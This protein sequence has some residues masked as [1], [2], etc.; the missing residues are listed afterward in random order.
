MPHYLPETPHSP[1]FFET[2]SQIAKTIFHI[3]KEENIS[4]HS[5]TLGLFGKWGSGKSL[6]IK[7]IKDIIKNEADTSIVLLE[8]DVW[9]YIDSSLYRSILFDLERQ[10]QN[11]PLAR[12]NEHFIEGYK[13]SY[14]GESLLQIL[15]YQ[16]EHTFYSNTNK[17]TK[18]VSSLISSL[19]GYCRKQK[20]LLIITIV[21][22]F[23][24]GLIYA[25]KDSIHNTLPNFIYH[26]LRILFLFV[27]C[28]GFIEFIKEFFKDFFK[29]MLPQSNIIM[30]TTAPTFAQ[31][32]FEKIFKDFIDQIRRIKSNSK[33]A[34]VFDNLDRCDSEMAL[35]TLAGL[36]TFMN[37]PYCFYLIPCDELEIKKHLKEE[38]NQTGVIDKVFQSFIRIPYITEEDKYRFIEKCIQDAEFLI[39]KSDKSK[40]VQVLTY[41]YEG[42]TPRQ[43]KRFFNDF[44]SYYKLA[45]VVDKDKKFL[46]KNIGMFTFMITLKQK[47][48]SVEQIIISSPSFFIEYFNTRSSEILGKDIGSF[49]K[50]LDTCI[51]W[52]DL[53]QDPLDFI[54]FKQIKESSLFVR[55]ALKNDYSKLDISESSI[56]EIN[57]ILTEYITKEYWKFF[58]DDIDK[59][60]S[61]ISMAIL[62]KKEDHII[63]SLFECYWNNLYQYDLKQPTPGIP[64][65]IIKHHELFEKHGDLINTLNIN[66]IPL[67]QRH[68]LQAITDQGYNKA[69]SKLFQSFLKFFKPEIIQNFFSA[70]NQESIDITKNFL[71][72]INRND[73]V[74]FVPLHYITQL[75]NLTNVN[76]TPNTN[77]E[78]L[79]PFIGTDLYNQVSPL[80]A[81]KIHSLLSTFANYNAAHINDS[82]VLGLFDFIT[83]SDERDDISQIFAQNLLKRSRKLLSAGERDLGILYTIKALLFSK[84][85]NVMEELSSSIID[86]NNIYSIGFRANFIEFLNKVK[87]D[88]LEDILLLQKYNHSLFTIIGYYDLYTSFNNKISELF[89]KSELVNPNII[90]VLSAKYG[91]GTAYTDITKKLQNFVLRGMSQGTA[92]HSF[93]G[94]KDPAVGF[95]KTLHVEWK[96]NDIKKARTW[97]EGQSYN[98]LN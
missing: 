73:L 58:E 53:E 88:E 62:E 72:L 26:P 87:Q 33:I 39:E 38:D 80:I 5:F 31:D 21:S 86:I 90:T 17:A 94:I 52:I 46:L 37:L 84:D 96:L 82:I 13:S 56:K 3:I 65:L 95:A 45:L 1:D 70:S 92:T 44:I 51:E 11:H 76:D 7:E 27:I 30:Q 41:A 78:L 85:N 63:K 2:H 83:P 50:Y 43:I 32:Q 77:L 66:V 24:A 91:V 42:D 15:N 55:R 98:L 47:W 93:L 57:Y 36:K 54:Y 64:S 20:A 10:L 60:S 49:K 40:I 81:N 71:L 8:F 69:T 25:F 48:P 28:V 16:R 75:V 4:K 19:W 79:R 35:K 29:E 14:N 59:V 6:V 89:R 23:I 97:E 67:A 12:I 61:I 18:S 9:K 68:S 74:K 34:I 22:I